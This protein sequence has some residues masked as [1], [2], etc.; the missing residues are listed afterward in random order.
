MDTQTF[1]SVINF[2]DHKYQIDWPFSIDNPNERDTFLTIS[3]NGKQIDEIPLF[4]YDSDKLDQ[5]SIIAIAFEFISQ[6][7]YAISKGF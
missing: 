3:E 1:V 5:I 7:Q 4:L 6:R 2:D